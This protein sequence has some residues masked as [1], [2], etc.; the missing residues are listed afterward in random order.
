MV[1]KVSMNDG[2]QCLYSIRKKLKVGG[3]DYCQNYVNLIILDGL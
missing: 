1:I 3:G 2:E